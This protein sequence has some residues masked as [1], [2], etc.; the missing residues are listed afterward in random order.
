MS[1]W[2]EQKVKELEIELRSLK[3]RVESLERENERLK[4]T[5]EKDPKTLRLAGSR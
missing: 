1:I 2:L 3:G 5:R 4:Q